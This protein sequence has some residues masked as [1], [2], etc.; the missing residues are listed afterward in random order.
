MINYVWLAEE[1][2]GWWL[3]FGITV[4]TWRPGRNHCNDGEFGTVAS[5]LGE[6]RHGSVTV[7][8]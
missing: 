2:T 3:C 5:G 6:L 7:H 8:N 4:K 1:G